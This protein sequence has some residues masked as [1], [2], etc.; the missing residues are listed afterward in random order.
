MAT[1]YPTV[2]VVF[3]FAGSS[4]Q[5][6]SRPMA[7]T[8][9]RSSSSGIG[10]KRDE[11]EMTV[12]AAAKEEAPTAKHSQH[13]GEIYGVKHLARRTKVG[14]SESKFRL[15]G[16]PLSQAEDAVVPSANTSLK[17]RRTDGASNEQEARGGSGGVLPSPTP[18]WQAWLWQG[19]TTAL[20][21]ALACVLCCLVL[22]CLPLLWT[23][24]C[25]LPFALESYRC[26]PSRLSA[27]RASRCPAGRLAL[28]GRTG[29]VRR[30]SLLLLVPWLAFCTATGTI[31]AN[32]PTVCDGIYSGA[33]LRLDSTSLT[34]SLPTQLGALTA[35]TQMSLSDNSLSGPR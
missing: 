6:A 20:S 30:A 12:G 27:L 18:T 2:I 21:S 26:Q 35:L 14:N 13:L 16:P 7:T 19:V 31:C 8:L 24:H 9:I 11:H 4:M 28:G 33:E 25:A 34:G 1:R 23:R 17:S 3:I 5:M 32:E 22:V 29:A 15:Q 10:G